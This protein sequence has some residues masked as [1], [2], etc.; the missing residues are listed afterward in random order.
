MRPWRVAAL[1]A[2]LVTFSLA[3]HAV[4]LN[5]ILIY[6]TD[7]IGTPS[8]F[9]WTT[10]Q[11]HGGQMW[12]TEAAPQ[13]GI[14][15]L[16]DLPPQSFRHELLNADNF[17]INVPLPEGDNDFTLLVQWGP[18]S[19]LDT[20]FVI[21]L[22]FDGVLDY[23]GISALFP[24]QNSLSAPP[25]ARNGSEIFLTFD[26]TALQSP[27]DPTYDDGT[28]TVSIREVHFLP[29]D[30]FGG[31]DLISQHATKPGDG[32]DL[33]AVLR[34]VVEPSERQPAGAADLGGFRGF[35]GSVTFGPTARVGPDVSGGMPAAE[36][37]NL[38]SNSG[39]GVEVRG[40]EQATEADGQTTSPSPST[41]GKST[42]PATTNPTLDATPV[43]TTPTP[44][45]T[46]RASSPAASPSPMAER[47]EA[48][49][50][51]PAVPTSP[52]SSPTHTS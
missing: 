7:Q 48:T 17:Q 36:Y 31:V 42:T 25:P 11:I 3:A 45:A 50:A 15:V 32:N 20:N 19:E 29:P 34:L 37:G 5:G 8:G 46:R 1:S 33:I 13:F 2:A 27:T 43:Q 10:G 49:K 24:H 44:N 52:A 41:A 6:A 4:T 21:N 51:P 28:D 35:S 12:R 38:A 47:N 14:G 18:G 30:T 40:T 39:S 16:S 23:P 22:F 9:D 26:V